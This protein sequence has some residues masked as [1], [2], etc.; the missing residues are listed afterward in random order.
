MLSPFRWWR[1]NLV[2]VYVLFGAAVSFSPDSARSQNLTFSDLGGRESEAAAIE[3]IATK[4]IIT[5]QSP[6]KFNPGGVF[7]R[8]DFAVAAQKLFSLPMPT[9]EIYFADVP[10]GSAHYEAIQAAA[11]FMDRRPI[12][13]GCLMSSNFAPNAPLSHAH[14]AISLA[15]MEVANN[16]VALVE[17]ADVG[18]ALEGVPDVA[19]LSPRARQLIATAIKSGAI[20]PSSGHAFEPA[21]SYDR[22]DIALVLFNTEKLLNARP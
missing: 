15:R 7:T 1:Q 5:P 11:P 13:P 9:K 19:R 21:A 8:G 16:R 12:C 18:S 10:K 22:G 2:M 4:G 3:E 14:A 17:P 6:G 20:T